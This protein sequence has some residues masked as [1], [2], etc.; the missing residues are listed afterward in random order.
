MKSLWK[1]L[2]TPQGKAL[3][4]ALLS[5]L[6]L[7]PAWYLLGNWYRADLIQQE[8]AKAAEQI[9]ACANALASAVE[10]RIALLQ[11]LY[12][13]TRTEWPDTEFDQSFEIYSSE[14]YFNSTGVRTLMIAPEGIARYIFPIYNSSLLSGYDLLNHPDPGHATLSSVPS[15][16]AA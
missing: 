1:Q 10:Q 16:T 15:S 8:R 13:F 14:V 12:A 3:L 9:S 6:V 4:P 2:R 7:L 11:G 5:L